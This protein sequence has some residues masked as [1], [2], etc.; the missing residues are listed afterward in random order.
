MVIAEK[1]SGIMNFV[2]DQSTISEANIEDTLQLGAIY[3][4]A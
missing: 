1:L 4:V 3:C 2:S